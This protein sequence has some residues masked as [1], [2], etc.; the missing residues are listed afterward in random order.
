[1]HRSGVPQLAEGVQSAACRGAVL[2][3]RGAAGVHVH[4]HRAGG[5]EKKKC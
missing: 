2:G 4:S 5:I 3:A 1:M